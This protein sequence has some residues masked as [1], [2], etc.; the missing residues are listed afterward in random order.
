M[1][2]FTSETAL[3]GIVAFDAVGTLVTLIGRTLIP[4]LRNFTHIAHRAH[5]AGVACGYWVYHNY[6]PRKHVLRVRHPFKQVT[7]E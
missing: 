4:A 5:L 3:K 2:Q 1:Y 6:L 7:R